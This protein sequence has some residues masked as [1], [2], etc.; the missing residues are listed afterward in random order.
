M[1]SDVTRLITVSRDPTR[2]IKMAAARQLWSF[3]RFYSLVR[4]LDSVRYVL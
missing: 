3:G 2:T 4:C 1:V